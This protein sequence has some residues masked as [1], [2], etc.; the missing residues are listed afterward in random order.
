ML[1]ARSLQTCESVHDNP[2]HKACRSGV[3]LRRK[4]ATASLTTEAPSR[5]LGG[6]ASKG[7]M[8]ECGAVGG[9]DVC[10]GLG[11]AQCLRHKWPVRVC[12]SPCTWSVSSSPRRPRRI[13]VGRRRRTTARECVCVCVCV[14]VVVS[15]RLLGGPL[16]CGVVACGRLSS[17]HRSQWESKR[18]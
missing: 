3:P 14:C 17:H 12:V 5:W 18:A 11:S 7:T 10:A 1:I 16:C 9:A 2:H 15:I 4:A 8:M 6:V 13:P